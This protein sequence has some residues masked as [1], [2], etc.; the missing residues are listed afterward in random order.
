MLGDPSKDNIDPDK[1]IKGMSS[2]LQ[3]KDP[4]ALYPL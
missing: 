3:N 1:L 4:Q 2:F